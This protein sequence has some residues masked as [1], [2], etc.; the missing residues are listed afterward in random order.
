M[1]YFLEKIFLLVAMISFALIMGGFTVETVGS[2]FVSSA[3]GVMGLMAFEAL[4]TQ[5]FFQDI[6]ENRQEMWAV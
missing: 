5:M 4:N 6:R 1:K 3:G 2:I